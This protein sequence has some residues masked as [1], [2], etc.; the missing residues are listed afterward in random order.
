MKI[1]TVVGATNLNPNYYKFIP[2]QIHFWEKFNIHFIAIVVGTAIPDE[3][4]PFKDHIILWDKTPELHSIF[5]AQNIR[6]YFPS[7]LTMVDDAF[8]R[9]MDAFVKDDFV[10]YRTV[11]HKTHEILICYN[12]AHPQTWSNIFGIHSEQDI[13]ERLHATYLKGD[14]YKPGSSGW[15]IVQNTMYDYLTQYPRFHELKRQIKR[16]EIDVF[17]QRMKRVPFEAFI[18][19]FDDAHFQ[20]NFI[21][22]ETMIVHAKIQFNNLHR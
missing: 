12:A 8:Q 11:S 4:L 19:N 20:R 16:L 7:L 15:I 13:V 2:Y 14:H 6:I 1:T 21:N 18:Q 3:L 22:Y 5:V 9:G 17:F 10:H